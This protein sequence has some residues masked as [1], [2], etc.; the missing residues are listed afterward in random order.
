M[1]YLYA[2]QVAREGWASFLRPVLYVISEFALY[3]IPL[4]AV[5]MYI[6]VD[7]KKYR[8][9]AFTIL[10][11]N[12]LTN[13]VKLFACVYRPW[14]RDLRLHVDPLAEHS[15]TGYS[16]PSGHTTAGAAFYGNMGYLE[17]KAKKRTWVI[18]LMAV[19]ILLTGFSRNFLGAH[20]LPDVLTAIALSLGCM[21]LTDMLLEYVD[22]NP[23]KDLFLLIAGVGICIV[24]SIVFLTKSY[25]MDTGADGS[26]LV[27]YITVQKDTWL[28]IGF[29]AA[30]LICW[31]WDRHYIKFTTD[32]DKK[33]KIIRA[34]IA[35]VLFGLLYEGILKKLAGL[36]DIRMGSLIR[37]FFTI[38]IVAGIYPLIFTKVEKRKNE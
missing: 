34:V 23:E 4:I 12:F 11:S 5:V 15:A 2:L 25:P 20:S 16:F 13:S 27:D 35:T 28:A 29:V 31:Y 26:L 9:L 24:L 22:E 3:G 8:L 38:F 1:D 7:K 36:M 30:W 33:S 37:G 14:I 10:F 32:I 18:V 17:Y 21:I 19:M 6:C